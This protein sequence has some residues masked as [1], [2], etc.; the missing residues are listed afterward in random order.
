LEGTGLVHSS[1]STVGGRERR[2]Y[3]LT[4]AG[5]GALSAERKFASTIGAFF[6]PA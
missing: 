4:P 6:R 5:R 1:W 3:H 2:F